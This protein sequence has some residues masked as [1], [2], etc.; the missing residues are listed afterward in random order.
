MLEW[1][2]QQEDYNPDERNY[3]RLMSIAS[4]AKRND[5]AQELFDEMTN[6][7]M[8][9][10]VHTYTCLVHAHADSGNLLR[11]E[12]IVSGMVEAGIKPDHVTYTCLIDA[13]GKKNMLDEMARIYNNMKTVG[14]VPDKA[15]YCSIVHAYA[16]SGLTNRMGRIYKD[17]VADGWGSDAPCVNQMIQAYAVSGLIKDME[18]GYSFLR[19]ERLSVSE[20][21]I[22]AMALA[23]IHKCYFFQL[24]TFVRN[25]GLKRNNV[26]NL[27]WNL[28]LLS[29]AAN[30]SMAN[31]EKEFV[32]MTNAGFSPDISTFNIRARA[33][34]NMHMYWDL[35]VTV[36]H[37]LSMGIKPDL[38]TFDAIFGAYLGGRLE[39]QL[40]TALQETKS[41]HLRPEVRTESFVCE[42]FG[43][44]E[45][46]L[47]CE[48]LLSHMAKEK[49]RDLCYADLVSLYLQYVK[50]KREDYRRF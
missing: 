16:R 9:H 40:A 34:S 46:H 18:A 17:M 2:Q 49:V 36:Q 23:Y 19:N 5:K 42:A 48:E 35:H 50:R 7:G 44:G 37:M 39:K 6:K 15:T 45:F 12:K 41:S 30:F 4:K 26:K 43:K 8:A 14:C 25:A 31:L 21:T 10:N 11:A 33:F 27:L 1:Y 22:R 32:N 28:L 13:Y 38:I 29:F 24:S 47:F 3:C 20:Q